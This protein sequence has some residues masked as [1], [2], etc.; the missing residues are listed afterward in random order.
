MSKQPL[1]SVKLEPVASV[2]AFRFH[3][4]LTSKTIYMICIDL[5]VYY[6]FT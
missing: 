1:G 5:L 3:G 2:E 6:K 4:L